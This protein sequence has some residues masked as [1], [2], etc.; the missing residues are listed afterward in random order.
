MAAVLGFLTHLTLDEIWSLSLGRTG[1][2][3]KKSSGT[4]LKLF[5]ND[6]LPNVGVYAKLLVL[7]VLAFG[8]PDML[9]NID[10]SEVDIP[11]VARPLFDENSSKEETEW[12]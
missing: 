2:H 1:V 4:A 7:A 5:G 6:L 9:P 11:Q 12:R 3:V 8:D 10:E